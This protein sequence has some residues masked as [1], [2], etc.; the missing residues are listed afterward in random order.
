VISA[1]NNIFVGLKDS[2]R[3]N[4]ADGTAAIGPAYLTVGTFFNRPHL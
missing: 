1:F 3:E 4:R 2:K